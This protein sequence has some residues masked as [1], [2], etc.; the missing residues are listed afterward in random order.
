MRRSSISVAA[1]IAEGVGRKSDKD[2]AHFLNIAMA[3]AYETQS[4][5]YLALDLG[6]VDQEG[7]D[8]VYTSLDEMCRMTFSL[9]QSLGVK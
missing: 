2:F 4:H 9:R 7:F 6:Y 8:I 1:N 5:M 3:S